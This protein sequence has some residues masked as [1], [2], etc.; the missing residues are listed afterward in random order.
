MILFLL[1]IELLLLFS[2]YEALVEEFKSTHKAYEDLS[3][4]KPVSELLAG[5]KKYEHELEC[6]QR[7]TE[8]VKPRVRKNTNVDF[9]KTLN[10][11]LFYRSFKN[12]NLYY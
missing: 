3:Q 1:N 11:Y 7:K 9:Y 2:Q 4:H 6:L 12:C 10:V 5:I 8:S